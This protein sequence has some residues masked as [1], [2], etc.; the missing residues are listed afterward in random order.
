MIESDTVR[1]LRECD[2]G[3]TMGLAALHD[4]NAYV[5]DGELCS[6]LLESERRH[7]RLRDELECALRECGDGGKKPNGV[8]RAMSSIKTN[9]KLAFDKGDSAPAEVI[10]DGCGMGVKSLSRYLNEYKAADEHSKGIARRLISLEDE[11]S[12]AVRAYL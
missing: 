11:L 8:A 9:V 1:L 12:A 10:F 2:A 7:K 6:L 4:V 5:H 3:I